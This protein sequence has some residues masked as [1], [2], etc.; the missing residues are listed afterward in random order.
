VTAPT[1]SPGARAVDSGVLIADV[2]GVPA[3]QGSTRAF[4]VK[5]RA[6]TTSANTRLKPWREAVRSTLVEAAGEAWEPFTGPVCVTVTFK[7]PKPVSA[8]KRRRT[9]PIGAR[10]GDLDKLARAILDAATD[11]GIWRDDSQVTVLVA[12]KDYVADG[13]RPGAVI[14]INED[15]L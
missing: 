7:M 1:R 15:E 14:V 6:V 8:P 2:Y 12:S 9:W 3:T 4:V 10:S 5:G 11:A 13:G